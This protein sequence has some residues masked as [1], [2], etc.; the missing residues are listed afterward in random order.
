MNAYPLAGLSLW[1]LTPYVP[2]KNAVTYPK[3]NIEIKILKSLL[4]NG[5]IWLCPVEELPSIKKKV[6]IDAMLSKNIIVNINGIGLTS[7]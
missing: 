7:V 5:D 6:Q 1:H 4:P 2:I 3:T